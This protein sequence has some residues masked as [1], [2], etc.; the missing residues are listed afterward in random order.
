VFQDS[1][2]VS[3]A[4]QILEAGAI[5]DECLGRSV[6]KLGSGFT[7]A[8][9][10]ALLRAQAGAPSHGTPSNPCWVCQGA[11]DRIEEWAQEAA[12]RVNDVEFGTYRFGMIPSVRF[13]QMEAFYRERFPSEHHENLKHAF[14][15]ALGMAFEPLLNAPA[16]VGFKLPDVAFELD[17]TSEVLQ[18]RIESVFLFGR[19]K[20]HARGIPQTR[21]PCRACKGR[22]CEVCDSTGLQYMDS[23]ESLIAS[24]ILERTLAAEGCLHGAGREDID[25]RMLGNG[26]PFVFEAISP[27]RRAIDVEDLHTQITARADGK[28]E[29]TPLVVVHKDSVKWVKTLRASKRYRAWV[30]FSQPVSADALQSATGALKGPIDQQTPQRVAHRRADRV[31][32]RHVLEMN[33]VLEEPTRAVVEVHGDGGLY[34]KELISGD[35]GRTTPSLAEALG[36]AAKVTA[37]DVVDVCG[38]ALPDRLAISG[39]SRKVTPGV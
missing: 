11:F 36:C 20:K 24:P 10:G 19:Y 7:N 37:L 33:G 26:R 25:A 12:A 31:R 21:W 16:T 34:I 18:L 2:V 15:R 6:G 17:L 3:L 14:N 28:V 30:E 35:E 29:V 23:V 39:S 22:G 1:N 9:R 8:R 13:E 32:V 5:C 38:G 27:K 4:R